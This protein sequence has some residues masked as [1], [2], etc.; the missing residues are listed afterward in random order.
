ML[1]NPP[2]SENRKHNKI[3]TNEEN[4][5]SKIVL[6]IV[7]DEVD[8]SERRSNNEP[9]TNNYI[10]SVSGISTHRVSLKNVQRIV[11]IRRASNMPNVNTIYIL[12]PSRSAFNGS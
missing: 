10:D 6:Q 8:Y 1:P 2:T 4:S 11:G 12:I 7:L 3:K 5:I 9:G